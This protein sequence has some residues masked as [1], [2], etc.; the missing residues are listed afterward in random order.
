MIIRDYTSKNS[1]FILG[2]YIFAGVQGLTL[3][4]FI[5]FNK[6]PIWKSHSLCPCEGWQNGVHTA[7][8]PFQ[9]YPF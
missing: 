3:L 8:Y 5:F 6:A 7:A 4:H 2:D 1:L 9:A